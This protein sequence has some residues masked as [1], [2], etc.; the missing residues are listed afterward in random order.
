MGAVQP[1][2]RDGRTGAGEGRPRRGSDQYHDRIG[3]G[4]GDRG[5]GAIP[6][7]LV[8]ALD[9]TGVRVV[10]DAGV[11]AGHA[12]DWTGR[13][14]G[15]VLGMVRPTSTGQV[16][17]VLGAARAVGVPVQVQGGNTGLVGGSVPDRPSLLLVTTGLDRLDPVDAVERTV[18]AGAGVP[19]ARL[20]AH[21]VA[22]GLRFGVDLAARE[23]ATVGGMAATNAGGIGVLAHGMMREQVRGLTAVLA[24]GRV[25]STVGRPRK[26]NAGYPLAALLVGAE[27]TLGVITEVELALHPTPPASTVAAVGVTRLADA[28]AAARLVGGPGAPLLAAEVVD[29]TGVRRAVQAL[30]V[31]DPLPPDAAWLV[32]LEVADGGTGAGLVPV[33][34]LVAAVGTDAR[35]RAG[36]WAI[37]E[38]QTE[39]YATLP[40]PPVD[41][42]DVS[43]RLD[44]LDALVERVRAVVPRAG[45]FGHV[46][47]GNLHVQLVG[48][49]PG[50]PERV[51]GAVAELGGSISA[52]HGIGRLKAAHLHLARSAAEVAWM[53]QLKATVDPQGLL[54]PGVLLADG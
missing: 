8:Q 9:A 22:A 20:A 47:D 14:R 42:L 11:L 13:W 36:L 43:V 37:R 2:E 38:R 26:D 19:A 49:G 51:L 39:Q 15:P 32:L 34:D 5:G 29:A 52:E 10:T 25:L 18:L 50:D 27:G 54:N 28:V 16:A 7:R 23:S 44:R 41:K 48:A 53:R 31:A 46:L 12:I 21:A 4:V 3:D 17:A 6:A 30:G 24:D 35:D 40:G 45:V 33:A 1:A